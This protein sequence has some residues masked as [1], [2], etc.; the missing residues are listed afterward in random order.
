MAV[1]KIKTGGHEKEYNLIEMEKGQYIFVPI[2]QN[3]LLSRECVT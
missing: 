2:N 3:F 1:W